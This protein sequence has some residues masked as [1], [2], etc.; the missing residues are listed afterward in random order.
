M[1]KVT[2]ERLDSNATLDVVDDIIVRDIGDGGFC[3]EKVLDVGSDVFPLL[4]FAH[5]QG[6]SS[7]YSMQ[8]PL[9]VVDEGL[10]EILP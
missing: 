9:K 5:G 2:V 3:V 7:S 6:V 4:L 10:L 8:R 1:P